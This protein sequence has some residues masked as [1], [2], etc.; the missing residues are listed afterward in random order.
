M[1]ICNKMNSNSRLCPCR[2]YRKQYLYVKDGALTFA[3]IAFRSV[4]LCSSHNNRIKCE[5]CL[6]EK[7][8]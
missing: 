1:E 7:I 6:V 5:M 3:S 4:R 2:V 8:W